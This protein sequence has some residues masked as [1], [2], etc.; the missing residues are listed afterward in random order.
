ML[1]MELT[2]AKLPKA[3]L[4]IGNLNKEEPVFNKENY[5]A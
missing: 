3:G 2:E 4:R 1:P 5:H